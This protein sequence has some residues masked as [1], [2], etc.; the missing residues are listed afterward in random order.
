[1]ASTVSTLRQIRGHSVIEPRFPGKEAVARS[2]MGSRYLPASPDPSSSPSPIQRPIEATRTISNLDLHRGISL[3]N[4]LDAAHDLRHGAGVDAPVA[5]G[6][7]RKDRS[8]TDQTSRGKYSGETKLSQPSVVAPDSGPRRSGEFDGR[9]C[10]TPLER[11]RDQPLKR[12]RGGGKA[13]KNW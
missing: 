13:Q 5:E 8:E 7:R 10:T 9:P 11:S 12:V 2:D 3:C 1:M 6:E 4:V